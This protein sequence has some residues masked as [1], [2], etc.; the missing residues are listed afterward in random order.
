M[1]THS[2]SD[3]QETVT[4]EMRAT[5]LEAH[6]EILKLQSDVERLSS[7]NLR[8]RL[9]LSCVLPIAE[10]HAVYGVESRTCAHIRDS[11]GLGPL[12]SKPALVVDNDRSAS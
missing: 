1:T 7:E 9:M 5:C 10:R 8:L 11:L 4:P 6:D 2:N 12:A 3:L